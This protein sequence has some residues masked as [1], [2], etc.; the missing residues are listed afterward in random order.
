M[1]IYI[2]LTL[3]CNVICQ[4]YHKAEK[5]NIIF[6]FFFVVTEK[7]CVCDSVVKN[8]HAMQEPQ[9]LTLG[10]VRSPGRGHSNPL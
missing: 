4:L 9:G 10:L 3:N 5:L 2:Y 7:T 1:Y 8:P 6:S